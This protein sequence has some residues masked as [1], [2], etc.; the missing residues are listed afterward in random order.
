MIGGVWLKIAACALAVLG[1]KEF[2][3]LPHKNKRPKYVDVIIY[4]L[5]I[6]LVFMDENR[7]MY[8]LLAMLIP[9]L[10]VIYCNDNKKYNADEAFKLIG[11]T[12]LVGMVFHMFLVIREKS[13][14]LFVY[15]FLITMLTDTYAH[16]AGTLIGKHKFA[17]KISPNKTWE[18]A[19]I[20]G[21]F[22]TLCASTFYYIAVD[23]N[24]NV[25]QNTHGR[26]YR[27]KVWS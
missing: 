11:M 2:L 15:L 17:P 7:Q 6:L 26:S 25:L 24:I 20:G 22:G 8:Y 9:M 14:V 1:I 23:S 16:L 4:A 10:L 3:D 5:T 21:I 18:G 13:L 27:D 19:I 12:I